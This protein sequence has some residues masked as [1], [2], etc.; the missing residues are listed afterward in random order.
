MAVVDCSS[1]GEAVS[2]C[3]IVTH[4]DM[5][6]LFWSHLGEDAEATKWFGQSLVE[7]GIVRSSPTGSDGVFSVFHDASV[8][9]AVDAMLRHSVGAVPVVM[10]CRVWR[11]SDR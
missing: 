11:G 10:R 7:L 3:K 8:A 1:D 6:R 4:V 5:L 2:Q 9:S